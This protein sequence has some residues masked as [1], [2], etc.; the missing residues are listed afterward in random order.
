[1]LW[2]DYLLWAPSLFWTIL[3]KLIVY[4][5]KTELFLVLA[6]QPMMQYCSSQTL[7]YLKHCSCI[8]L[9]YFLSHFY[10]FL[11]LDPAIKMYWQRLRKGIIQ[12]IQSHLHMCQKIYLL[13]RVISHPVQ[14]QNMIP[15]RKQHCHLEVINTLRFILLQTTVLVLCRQ[16]Q[17][18]NLHRLKVLSLKHVMLLAFQALQ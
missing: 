16:F 3:L 15:S 4:N 11:L 10:L 18:A 13:E 7:P 6:F 17:G 1:M 2:L 8:F 12:I 9:E 14:P 5:F